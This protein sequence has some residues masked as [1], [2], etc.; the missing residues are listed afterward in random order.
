ML[1]TQSGFWVSFQPS[2][3]IIY[4]QKAQ[5]DVDWFEKTAN[6]PKYWENIINNCLRKLS[7]F[8]LC[9][10]RLYSW[11]ALDHDISL[12]KNYTRRSKISGPFLPKTKILSEDHNI[13]F[14]SVF[15]PKTDLKTPKNSTLTKNKDFPPNSSK[16]WC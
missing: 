7:E 12:V 3:A 14:F 11:T 15:A 6:V 1:L 10:L 5:S 2:K 9:P 16:F 13:E 4:W 8:A